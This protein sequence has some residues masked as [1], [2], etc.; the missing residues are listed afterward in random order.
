[1][2]L[3]LFN[4]L[5]GGCLFKGGVVIGARFA[6][7]LLSCWFV[8]VFLYLLF[9]YDAVLN[10]DVDKSCRLFGFEL[11]FKVNRVCAR[12]NIANFFFIA[13]CAL[14]LR[15][16]VCGLFAVLL[17]ILLR[18]LWCVLRG[19]VCRFFRSGFLFGFGIYSR[20]Q[21]CL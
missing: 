5:F 3:F 8:A 20:T 15:V 17:R 7:A 21:N 2:E 6:A 16:L 10:I 12:V 18:I 9:I 13:R 4:R 14:L 1:M 11:L 19:F